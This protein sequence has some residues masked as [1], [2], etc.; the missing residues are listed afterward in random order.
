M[1][2][3]YWT[4]QRQLFLY[5]LFQPQPPKHPS[6]IS[7]PVV[8][9]GSAPLATKP[10]GID[11][12]FSLMTINASQ[13]HLDAWGVGDPHVTFV[14][15]NQIEG[16]GDNA[17]AVRRVL[18]ERRTGLLYIL[19][20]KHNRSRLIQGLTGMH[21]A[22]KDLKMLSRND[23]MALHEAIF[24][25][26]HLEIEAEKKFSNGI[27]AMLYAFNSGARQVIMSGINPAS[28]GHAYNNLNLKRQHASVDVEMIKSLMKQG[29]SVFTADPDVSDALGI[30]HWK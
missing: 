28:A 5:R 10:Y 30:P 13:F 3:D 15:R 12:S 17:V 18:K 11:P 2:R 4:A 6:P 24:G 14:Q 26:P 16:K 9:V 20:W 8:V 23:I 19:R 22:Y 7:G 25:H 1:S 29:R 27:T 21:Y